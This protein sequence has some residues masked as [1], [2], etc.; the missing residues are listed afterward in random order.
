[1]CIRDRLLVLPG[2]SFVGYQLLAQQ[3][4]PDCMVLVAGYGES[5]TGYIPTERA[6]EDGFDH[7]WR[8][9]GRGCEAL[10][11]EKLAK[12]MQAKQH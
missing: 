1:M 11:H 8:W 12:L 10:I 6:F 9:V 4:R 2:E 7:G 5:W 3:L